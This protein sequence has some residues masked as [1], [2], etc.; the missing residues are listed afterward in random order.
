MP[1]TR[2]QKGLIIGLKQSK[3]IVIIHILKLKKKFLNHSK[4]DFK[5]IQKRWK[6]VSLSLIMFIYCI[7]KCHKINAN[8][9]GSYINS[10]DWTMK[11]Q[12]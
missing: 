8:R 9:G 6:V 2:R 10:P 11:K 7:I 12:K 1:E 4:K 3:I 5:I